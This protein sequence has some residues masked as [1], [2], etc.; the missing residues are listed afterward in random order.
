M[1]ALKDFAPLL[2]QAR[3]DAGLNQPQLA[4]LAG[5][6][7]SYIS[8]LESGATNPLTGELI[9]PDEKLVDRIADSL[10]S[11]LPNARAVLRKAAGYDSTPGDVVVHSSFQRK[12]DRIL[13][14]A[15]HEKR[16]IV[17]EMLEKDAEKYISLLT[18]A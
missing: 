16:S 14:K 13:S 2:K 4:Q 10:W 12:I 11:V 9:R 3:K 5:C 18:T 6:S 7:K 15:P 17:E 8:M 1:T